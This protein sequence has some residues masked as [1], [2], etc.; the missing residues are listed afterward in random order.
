MQNARSHLRACFGLRMTR[1]CRGIAARLLA[2]V[3][4]PLVGLLVACSPTTPPTPTTALARSTSVPATPTSAPTST[5]T[6]APSPQPTLTATRPE[7]FSVAQGDLLALPPEA[8]VV[9]LSPDGNSLLMLLPTGRKRP[10]TGKGEASVANLVSARADGSGSRQLNPEGEEV[11]LQG[12]PVYSPDGRLV[13][14]LV[15]RDPKQG[16]LHV[17]SN[18]G[19]NPRALG[20]ADYAR[21]FWLSDGGNGRPARVGFVRDGQFWTVRSDGTGAAPAAS[22]TLASTNL[23][24]LSPD[25]T[26]LA[27]AVMLG[28][29]LS[30][31]DGSNARTVAAK[32][33]SGGLVWSPDGRW[34]AYFDEG[35]HSLHV[36]SQN[37]GGDRLL[38]K[39][40][41]ESFY[42]LHWTDDSRWLVYSVVPSASFAVCY[43]NVRMIDISNG[44][45]ADLAP[46]ALVTWA[47][48]ARRMLVTRC[49]GDVARNPKIEQWLLT[50]AP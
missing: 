41:T 22:K 18:D 37:G 13:S 30:A 43:A 47:P 27:E 2:M 23:A 12:D 25:G 21:L 6:M 48:K 20:L 19:T 50:L 7:P 39:P 38:E 15:Y 24:A 4:L 8:I 26:R 11:V 9:A 32:I 46:G 3:G 14:Y 29:A 40:A 10:F 1:T 35:D 42:G 45:K 17:V 34:V 49:A 5:P 16:E 28:L 33:V 36:A 31:P 44:D